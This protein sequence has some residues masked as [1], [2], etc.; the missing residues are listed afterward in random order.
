MEDVKKYHPFEIGKRY[1]VRGQ[2]GYF[3]TIDSIHLNAQGGI[4]HFMGRYDNQVIQSLLDGSGLVP[5]KPLR[6]VTPKLLNIIAIG[7]WNVR[8]FSP[9]WVRR[10]VFMP[11]EGGEEIQ[12]RINTVEMGFGYS[13]RGVFLIVN[14]NT[15]ELKVEQVSE[16]AIN[17]AM[18]FFERILIA[19]P[20]TP[21]AAVGFNINLNVSNSEDKLSK[22]V[23]NLFSHSSPYTLSQVDFSEKRADYV[24]SIS[25]TRMPEGLNLNF[26]F[27]Y[28]RDYKFSDQTFIKH[29]E[30]ANSIIE[31]E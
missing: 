4:S 26:N 7:H 10:H 6:V 22:Y 19:L 3:Y 25:A 29:W 12:V 9:Q 14:E 15:L 30:E 5:E 21:L 31:L 28:E 27:H 16:I 23:N 1:A 24:V 20:H 2:K 8:L 11:E 13:Y 17:L 18:E